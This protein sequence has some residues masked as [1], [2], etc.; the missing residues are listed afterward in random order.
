[1]KIIMS[2]LIVLTFGYGYIGAIDNEYV[3]FDSKANKHGLVLTATG[4]L[5]ILK[6]FVQVLSM[7]KRDFLNESK[8]WLSILVRNVMHILSYMAQDTGRGLMVAL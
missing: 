2:F 3:G 4:M 8:E 5:Y 1:M 7:S 6:G